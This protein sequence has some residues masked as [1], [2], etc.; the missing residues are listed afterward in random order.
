MD[1]IEAKYDVVMTCES[2]IDPFDSTSGSFGMIDAR[3][4]HGRAPAGCFRL[5][6]EAGRT[7]LTFLWVVVAFLHSYFPTS[8]LPIPIH[9]PFQ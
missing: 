6:E 2:E 8:L 4:G 3:H 7:S 5:S 9:N 1:E